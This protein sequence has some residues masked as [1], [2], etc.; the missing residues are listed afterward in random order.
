MVEHYAA[1]EGQGEEAPKVTICTW[2]ACLLSASV[3][4][5]IST[6][7]QNVILAGCHMLCMLYLFLYSTALCF[8][9]YLFCVCPCM[10][11]CSTLPVY[12]GHHT[13]KHLRLTVRVFICHTEVDFNFAALPAHIPNSNAAYRR[14]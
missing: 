11:V 4:R 6:S 10:L 8:R 1:G 5:T 12:H 2:A 9:V 13:L 3:V 14:L 7:R